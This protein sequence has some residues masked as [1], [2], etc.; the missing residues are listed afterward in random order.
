[1]KHLK[2]L[3]IFNDDRISQKLIIAKRIFIIISFVIYQFTKIVHAKLDII[4][5]VQ[6]SIYFLF[7]KQRV[8]DLIVMKRISKNQI[9][10]NAIHVLISYVIMIRFY[11]NCYV[12]RILYIQISKCLL[13]VYA[14]HDSLCLRVNEWKVDRNLN[15]HFNQQAI[16][17]FVNIVKTDAIKNN[18]NIFSWNAK[19]RFE[20]KNVCVIENM[21]LS[22]SQYQAFEMWFYFLIVRCRSCY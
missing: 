6:K 10:R 18:V 2:L 15:V 9:A 3:R 8:L 5:N 7:E 1:M 19:T 21:R 22:K 11:A 16:E 12:Q 13:E 4:S 14:K 20:K 17:L